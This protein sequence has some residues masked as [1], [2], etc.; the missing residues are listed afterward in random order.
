MSGL[1]AEEVAAFDEELAAVVEVAGA[2]GE[3]G[4][5][6]IALADCSGLEGAEGVVEV[7]QVVV[8]AYVDDGAGVW[9]PGEQ[10]LGL[11]LLGALE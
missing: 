3:D 2:A 11:D 5:G 6:G 8:P 10:G 9:E 1:E 7:L 4:L